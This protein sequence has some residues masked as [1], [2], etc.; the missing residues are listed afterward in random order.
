ML[1]PEW[2]HFH[3][4]RKDRVYCGA[5][6]WLG[7]GCGEG[8]V[9]P[10]ALPHSSWYWE[11]PRNLASDPCYLAWR[12]ASRL[13]RHDAW[14]WWSDTE[15]WTSCWSWNSICPRCRRRGNDRS[16]TDCSNLVRWYSG[17]ILMA[18]QLWSSPW[19]SGGLHFRNFPINLADECSDRAWGIA[20]ACCH[21][22][23]RIHRS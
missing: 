2:P 15:G 17:F 5:V 19:L 20:T 23:F 4:C 10:L 8:R 18:S 11:S 7:W 6:A 22:S 12:S 16:D 14:P 1:P 3:R 21:K 9:L 13:I